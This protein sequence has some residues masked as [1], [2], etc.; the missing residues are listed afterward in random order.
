VSKNIILVIFVL[1]Y[2][3]T[4]ITTIYYFFLLSPFY[5]PVKDTK[6]VGLL[7]YLCQF[8]KRFN[9][10][11]CAMFLNKVDEHEVLKGGWRTL[12]IY[13]NAFLFS[14]SDTDTL[15]IVKVKAIYLTTLKLWGCHV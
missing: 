5:R 6:S 1:I 2:L 7:V 10:Q 3:Q 8:A 14:S 9:E 11:G 4:I 12:N 13:Y 15:N